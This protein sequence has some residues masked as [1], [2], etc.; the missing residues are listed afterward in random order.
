[1]EETKSMLQPIIDAYN[2]SKELC[3]K[4]YTHPVFQYEFYYRS[5][6]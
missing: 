4:S 5:S 6:W 1:L 3:S 2:E